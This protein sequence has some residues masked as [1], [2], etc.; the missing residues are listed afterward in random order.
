MREVAQR[1]DDLVVFGEFIEGERLTELWRPEK[2]PLEIA[3]R[4][5]VD[6]LTGLGALHNLRDAKQQPMKLAHG[7]L[8]PATIVLGLDGI[9][10]VLHAVARCAP[11]ASPEE[12]SLAYLSPEVASGDPYDARADV[13]GA[14]VLLWEALSGKRLFTQNDAAAN[15]RQVRA[16]PLPRATVPAKA[17]WASGLLDV[18]AK[19]L[20]AS[21][22]DRWP[23]AA[24]MAAEIRKSAG[25]KLA[26]ASTA[27]AFAKSAFGERVKKRHES[28]DA[29]AQVSASPRQPPPAPAP[30]A[31]PPPA[32]A[33]PEPPP[34][35]PKPP[36]P[37][38]AKA[39]LLPDVTT[40]TVLVAPGLHAPVTEVVELGSDILVDAVSTIS[41]VPPPSSAVGG[42]VLDPFTA[43]GALDGQAAPAVVAAPVVPI[44]PAP[45][46][47]VAPPP[48]SITG[49]PHFAAAIDLAPPAPPPAAP[50][51]AEWP[52]P[53][54][55]PHT[56]PSL[57]RESEE[58]A[59]QLRVGRRRKLLV[60]GGVGGLGAIVF[61]LAAVRVAQRGTETR[62][63]TSRPV[64]VVASAAPPVPQAPPPAVAPAALPVVTA[65]AA[66]PAAP[67]PA[68][69]ASTATVPAPS[70]QA[71]IPH[72]TPA[73]KAPAPHAAPA[74]APP[75]GAK[76]RPK[77]TYDPNSL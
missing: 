26:P 35:P 6:V 71:A 39:E 36:P 43:R 58:A 19:A 20:A 47:E 12:A 64:P 48:S 70:R 27:A 61:V 5:L 73:F 45:V 66:P 41:S 60:L 59:R 32:P 9:A 30:V 16:G 42:F 1:G 57:V 2:L 63:S 34:V 3:L 17:P 55:P 37:P 29:K 44:G 74:W 51:F 28:I 33:S 24:V 18:A 53:S 54:N 50:P 49:A 72:A 25:L 56:S 62:A 7:E 75:A 38:P 13:F 11:G 69:V 76:P 22:D 68:V 15:A 4:V 46:E 21:P 77:P 40:D 65:A 10:R 23:T 31:A 52:A 67:P 14:G 8:S